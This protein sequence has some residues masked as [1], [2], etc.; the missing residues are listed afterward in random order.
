MGEP[1]NLF[2]RVAGVMRQ[3]PPLPG[4]TSVIPPD[5]TPPSQARYTNVHEKK[6]G[7]WLSAE[8]ARGALYSARQL[9]TPARTGVGYWRMG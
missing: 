1:G 8:R 7:Q 9:R 3:V 6:D 2:R 5:G 4:T